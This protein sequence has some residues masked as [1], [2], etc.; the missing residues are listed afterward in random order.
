MSLHAGTN[1]MFGTTAGDAAAP[2]IVGEYITSL[3]ALG[4]A[5]NLATNVGST[6]TSIVLT[7][8]DWDVTGI[9][10]FHPGSTTAVTYLQG[11]SSLSPTTLGIQDTF[12][13]NPFSTATTL[14]DASE[15][16]PT[17]RFNFISTNT[18]Y[19]VAIAG[20]TVSTMTAYGSIRARRVR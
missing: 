8:G 4:G 20:F 10:D 2:G 6:V 15:T 5:V 1:V 18:V 12:F 16:L 13:T 9:I 11:G 19:L 17:R 14:I 3:V 7:A